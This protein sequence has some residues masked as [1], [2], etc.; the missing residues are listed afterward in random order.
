MKSNRTP[1]RT[2]AKQLLKHF[3]SERPDY[4]YLKDVFRKLREELEIKVASTPKKLPQIPT[5]DELRRYYDAVCKSQNSNHMI[6]IKTFLYTGVRV[7]E[8]IR[9][10]LIDLDLDQCQIRIRNGKGGKD[11]NVPFPTRFKEVLAMHS[12]AT[13][14]DGA[15][16]LF[17]STWK[18]QYTDRGVRKILAKYADTSGIKKTISPHKLRHFLFTWLKKKGI[19]DALIQP[20]SGHETRQSLEIYSKLSISDA[21]KEY[22]AVIYD[23]PV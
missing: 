17:E 1:A 20:Y 23:F 11:R 19:D 3:H 6:I 2:K 18:K 7:S 5:E 16:Y 8:L 22:D 21:Q 4:L 15:I 14:K 13:R 9:I 12:A 10:K